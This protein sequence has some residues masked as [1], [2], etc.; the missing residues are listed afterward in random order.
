MM[1]VLEWL[2]AQGFTKRAGDLRTLG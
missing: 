2:D 1:P